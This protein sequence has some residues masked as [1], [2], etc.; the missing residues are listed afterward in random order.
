MQ[1]YFF[2]QLEIKKDTDEKQISGNESW[3]TRDENLISR[4]KDLFF[5]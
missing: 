1:L 4:N 3:K 2:F 5:M